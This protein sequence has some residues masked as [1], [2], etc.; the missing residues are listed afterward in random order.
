MTEEINEKYSG[1]DVWPVRDAVAAMYEGQ[2]DALKA[3][4]PAVDDIAKA[5][6][7]ASQRLGET[8]RLIYVGAGTSGRLSILDGSEL[9]PTY[10]WPSERIV[11]C[12]AGGIDALIQ[13][14]EGAEDVAQDGQRWIQDVKAGH[15]DVVICVAASGRTPFTLGALKEAKSLGA[16]TIGIANNPETP[17]LTEAEFPILAE[18]GSEIIAGSTRM[19]AGTAQKIILNM[20]STAIMI[21][22]GRV[23]DGLMVDMVVS[24]DKLELRAI[25]MVSEIANCSSDTAKAAL[26][27]TQNNIKQAVLVC[28]GA[29][30]ADSASLLDQVG[31]NLRQALAKLQGLTP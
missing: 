16:M 29:T 3:V 24:N 28:S 10:S 6:E 14:Q 19:K 26:H 11:F 22:L 13:S 4:Q 1:L 9:G 31:G 27:E 20:L 7:T 17:L 23:Y 18:T 8:G 5:A 15:H 12:M 21:R 30:V 2:V 25:K